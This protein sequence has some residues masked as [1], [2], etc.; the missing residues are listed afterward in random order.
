VAV[1]KACVS[2]F[3]KNCGGIR[4]RTVCITYQHAVL[5]EA[6]YVKEKEGVG[7]LGFGFRGR[8]GLRTW[9]SST[10]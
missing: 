1:L 3:R 9:S 10:L 8:L 7:G 5:R 2:F 4:A 6:I